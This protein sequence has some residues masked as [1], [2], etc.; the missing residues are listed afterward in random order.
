[1]E[2]HP[3][4]KFSSFVK[5]NR[6]LQAQKENLT[7]VRTTLAYGAFIM[8]SV[9]SIMMF[10]IVFYILATTD[11]D[12]KALVV[13][14]LMD[15]LLMVMYMASLMLTIV[16]TAYILKRTKFKLKMGPI[17]FSTEENETNGNKDGITQMQEETTTEIKKDEMK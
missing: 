11:P 10:K 2:I 5:T 7:S 13:L 6:L 9:L 15:K 12:Q 8:W 14:G 17:E 3:I 1:M 4:K 16:M